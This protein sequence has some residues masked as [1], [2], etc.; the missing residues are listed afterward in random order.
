MILEI[1]ET[2]MFERSE[3]NLF[4]SPL[5]SSMEL[6]ERPRANWSEAK[7]VEQTCEKASS[8]AS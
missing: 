3:F 1:F 7:L 8:N 4:E 6:E 2:L 5:G